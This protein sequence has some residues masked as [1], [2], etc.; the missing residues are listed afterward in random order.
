LCF[1]LCNF[2]RFVLVLVDRKKRFFMYLVLFRNLEELNCTRFK[3]FKMFCCVCPCCTGIMYCKDN[4]SGKVYMQFNKKYIPRNTAYRLPYR[5]VIPLR[6]GIQLRTP[7][8]YCSL[9][10]PLLQIR[11]Q[12]LLLLPYQY[13]HSCKNR[14]EYGI[15]NVKKK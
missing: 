12:V 6:T 15:I 13:L 8:W 4:L 9:A 1:V 14:N 10:L 2:D 3:Y 11:V 5:Y 7:Y